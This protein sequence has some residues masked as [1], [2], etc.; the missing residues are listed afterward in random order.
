VQNRFRIPNVVL[1]ADNATLP[2]VL[3]MP[4]WQGRS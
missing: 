4:P 3:P 2:P 1:P